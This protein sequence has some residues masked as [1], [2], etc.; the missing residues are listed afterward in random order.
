ML[1]VLQYTWGILFFFC[2]LWIFLSAQS[3]SKASQWSHLSWTAEVWYFSF[4]IVWG[5]ACLCVQLIILIN[6][7]LLIFVYLQFMEMA[8]NNSSSDTLEDWFLAILFKALCSLIQISSLQW[9]PALYVDARWS[10]WDVLNYKRFSNTSDDCT[11]LTIHFGNN[12]GLFCLNECVC[13]EELYWWL[14]NTIGVW[15]SGSEHL[16][17]EKF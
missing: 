8:L 2:H 11:F 1:L 16:Y 15:G 5:V 13:Y 14:W 9:N 4:D 7:K 10:Y 12:W 6:L 3:L 17:L